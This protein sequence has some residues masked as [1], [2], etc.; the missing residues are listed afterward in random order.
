MKKINEALIGSGNI[1]T[2]LMIKALRNDSIK[3]LWMVGIDPDS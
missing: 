2:D 3:P 1:D